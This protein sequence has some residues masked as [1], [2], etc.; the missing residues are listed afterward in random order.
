MKNSDKGR[1]GIAEK[2]HTVLHITMPM[3]IH[4][5]AT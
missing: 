3:N 5:N 4:M 2:M 1:L